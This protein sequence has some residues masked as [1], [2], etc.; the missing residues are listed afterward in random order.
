[1]NVFSKYEFSATIGIIGINPYVFIPE[2]ILSSIF[3]DAKKDKGPI[4]VKGTINEKTFTQTLMKYAGDWRLYINT[5]MLKDSPKRIGETISVTISYD[6]EE[7]KIEMHPLLKQALQ[8]NKKA[9]KVFDCLSPSRQKEIV[10]Y[11]AN[12]KTEE[13]IKENIVK[14]IRFLIGKEKFAGRDKP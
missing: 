10:R 13:K 6:P 9:K 2:E 11:I 1:M 5:S 8:K 3:I 12:L 14:A 4:P 7:R